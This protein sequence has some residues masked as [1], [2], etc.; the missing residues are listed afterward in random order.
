M[1]DDLAKMWAACEGC[2][3][4]GEFWMRLNGELTHC[5][6]VGGCG[7]VLRPLPAASERRSKYAIPQG[8]PTHEY[9]DL[10]GRRWA[11][12]QDATPQSVVGTLRITIANNGG[13]FEVKGY[14]SDDMFTL[15]PDG[16]SR[17]ALDN[18]SGRVDPRKPHVRL[19]VKLGQSSRMPLWTVTPYSEPPTMLTMWRAHCAQAIGDAARRALLGT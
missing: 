13:P 7:G 1:A 2:S 5:A 11:D 16:W 14:A 9:V 8:K 4:Q 15:L 6:G 18:H 17:M 10:M 19:R 3:V 12:P